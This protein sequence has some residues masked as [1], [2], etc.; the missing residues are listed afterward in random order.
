MFY[1]RDLYVAQM[2]YAC[3]FRCVNLCLDRPITKPETSWAGDPH[4]GVHSCGATWLNFCAVRETPDVSRGQQ[5]T[6][7]VVSSTPKL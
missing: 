5:H 4:F 3:P 7:G 2:P 1:W 6:I